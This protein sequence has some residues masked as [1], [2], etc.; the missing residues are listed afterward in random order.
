MINNSL[1]EA[2][3]DNS[4]KSID[5][6]N[7]SR[8]SANVRTALL[9]PDFWRAS[10]GFEQ[11]CEILF[12]IKKRETSISLEIYYGFIQFISCLYVLPVVS[13]QMSAA[14]YSKTLTAE[15]IAISCGMGCMIAGIFANLPFIIAPPASISIF[16]AIYLRQENMD[17]NSGKV[18]VIFS[19]ILLTCLGWRPLG[20]LVAKLIPLPIQAGTA[21]GIG[22][23]TA[24][25]G[26]TEVNLIIAGKYTI[27]KMGHVTPEIVVAMAGLVIVA[28]SLHYHIKGGFCLA[29]VF[30]TSV[31]W[32]HTSTWPSHYVQLP[33]SPST[34]WESLVAI[35]WE[36]AMHSSNVILVF[37][38]L[39]LY[40]L[41]LNGLARSLS[42]LSGLT[43]T[44]GS[45]P[46]GRWLFIVCGAATI[47]SGCI[48]GP[49]I[50]ISPESAAGVKAGARTGLSTFVCGILFALSAFFCPLFT[51]V[52]PAGTC[53][54]LIVVGV[55]LFQ[56]VMRV[57][58]QVVKD[59]VPAYCALFFIP[60]SYSILEGV[61]FAYA[62]YILIGFFTGDL[63]VDAA[64]LLS[65][66]FPA[67]FDRS[68]IAKALS[69]S[70]SSDDY[71]SNLNLNINPSPGT[72][73]NS[74][75]KQVA[76]MDMQ[77]DNVLVNMGYAEMLDDP[78]IR[79]R[80][81]TASNLMPYMRDGDVE[82]GTGTWTGSGSGS[83]RGRSRSRGS[84]DMA[85]NMQQEERTVL[86]E[87]IHYG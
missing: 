29:L 22:L 83:G 82:T 32:T 54:L 77:S 64:T 57:E 74:N 41:A 34:S 69:L 75:P 23:I 59:A 15:A 4:I 36:S 21:I 66:Y 33:S 47:F 11:V 27:L 16:L 38:L 25:A 76:T 24:L 42:D 35:N 12:H 1:T 46:R 14:G 45:I 39:F 58:W 30:G 56:N 70:L 2:L 85:D 37:D 73:P 19:G 68:G 49:P 48:G 44:D 62:M 87:N 79:T 51:A 72:G 65:C 63:F 81:R 55:I 60:F 84:R 50:L 40:V 31:W 8:S 18:C 26:T 67:A 43:R 53:P 9:N 78:R 6:C 5:S 10:N 86:I 61:A 20:N 13:D 3:N 52:P 80:Q 7:I 71:E 28:V 17:V